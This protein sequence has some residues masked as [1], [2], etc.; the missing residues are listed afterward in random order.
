MGAEM[1]ADTPEHLEWVLRFRPSEAAPVVVHLARDC[2]LVDAES[3]R[4]IAEFAGRFAGRVYGLLLHDHAAMATRHPAYVSAARQL[5]ERLRPIPHCPQVFIEYAAGLELD[6]FTRFFAAIADLDR[7]SAAIDISH[8]GIRYARA[9]FAQGHGGAEVCDLK[10]QPAELPTLMPDVDAALAAG[11]AA[12][13]D[14]VDRLS[15]GTKPIH[16]HLHDGHPL[17]TF[18]RWGVADHLSFFAEIPLKFEYRGRRAV[19]TMFGPAGLSKVVA[20]ALERLGPARCSFTLEIHPTGEQLP[21]G[22]VASLFGHWT[23]KTNA[24]KMNHWLSVLSRNHE[25][26]RQAVQRALVTTS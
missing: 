17:S 5:Q 19:P 24:E 16:F 15:A 6:Q 8:V 21:L 7:I 11:A 20:R 10:S 23:D 22:E 13:L 26:L 2:N 12:A 9:T 18:S 1:H 25:L 3:Q 4:R 14:L